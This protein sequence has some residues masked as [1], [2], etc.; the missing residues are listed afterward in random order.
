M[1]LDYMKREVEVDS[2]AIRVA[3]GSDSP[4]R[5]AEEAENRTY[6]VQTGCLE[7]NEA[8]PGLDVV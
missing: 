4:P 3:V 5:N 6:C 7:A 1:C 8:M 2:I